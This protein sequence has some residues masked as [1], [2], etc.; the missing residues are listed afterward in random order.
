MALIAEDAVLTIE[1][2]TQ[3]AGG[4]AVTWGSAVDIRARGRNIEVEDRADKIN[5]K[6]LANARK[7]HRFTAGESMLTIEQLVDISGLQ[8]FSGGTLIGRP[9]RVTLKE[10][11]SLSTPKQWVG[12]IETWKWVIRDGEAQAENISIA[13]DLDATSY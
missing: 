1:I 12:G 8:Y 4:G 13:C 9:A 11:S 5:T 3:A 7:K 10:I 2:G 6:A